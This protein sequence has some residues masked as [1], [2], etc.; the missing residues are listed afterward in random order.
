MLMLNDL[1]DADCSEFMD[2]YFKEQ[3]PVLTS[4]T[5]EEQKLF[6]VLFTWR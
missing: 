2:T 4:K 3:V 6:S 1:V 5:E